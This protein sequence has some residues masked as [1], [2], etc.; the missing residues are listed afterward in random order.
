MDKLSVVYMLEDRNK[1]HWLPPG[2]V[3]AFKE[4]QEQ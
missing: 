1:L 2:A 4:Q 3:A